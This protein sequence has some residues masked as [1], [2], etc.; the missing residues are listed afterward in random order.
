MGVVSW[1]EMAVRDLRNCS[2]EPGVRAQL[3]ALAERQLRHPPVQGP[4]EGLAAQYDRGYAYR[5]AVPRDAP[6][7]D[8]DLAGLLSRGQDG[9]PF[10]DYF[11]VYRPLT[12]SE[13]QAMAREGER[14]SLIVMRLLRCSDLVGLLPP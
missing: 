6:T 14:A 4:D 11:F 10:G 1:H 5:R 9:F 3:L 7:V 12:P 2:N 13:A 8:E